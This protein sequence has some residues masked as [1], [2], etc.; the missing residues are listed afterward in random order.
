MS[1]D[2]KN[3][4]GHDTSHDTSTTSR[5]ATTNTSDRTTSSSSD[6]ERSIQT[7][8][9]GGGMVR[10]GLH[11]PIL[12]SRYAWPASPF[13]FMRRMAEDMDRLF[14]IGLAPIGADRAT[15]SPQV[16]ILRRGDSIVV[17]ADLPGLD[18]KDVKVEVDDG[19]LTISGER[20]EESEEDGTDFYRSERSYGK[21]F[22]AVPLPEGADA[23]HTEAT[24]K[25]GV[26]EITLSAPKKPENKTR[27][28]TIR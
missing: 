5:G 3:S 22:R 25:D 17:R 13:H 1:L 24:F 10:R 15:W 19:M 26:L 27:E 9:E 6:R 21:F 8:R 14:G 23:D 7:N 12:G 20:C 4:T 16:E 28:V 18:K 2:P 11:A